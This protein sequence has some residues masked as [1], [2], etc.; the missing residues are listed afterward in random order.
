MHSVKEIKILNSVPKANV[1]YL[2]LRPF[3]KRDEA[4]LK[5]LFDLAIEPPA[6]A[7]QSNE[8]PKG[9]TLCG[10]FAPLYLRP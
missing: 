3:H 5:F 6:T 10:R 1:P 7:L 4:R 9:V 2:E 8:D